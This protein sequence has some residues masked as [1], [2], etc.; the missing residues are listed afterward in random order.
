MTNAHKEKQSTDAVTGRLSGMPCQTQ[1][2]D[3]RSDGISPRT[4]AVRSIAAVG[5]QNCDFKF[6]GDALR[7]AMLGPTPV[8]NRSTRPTG[9]SILVKNG[10]PTVT[11]SCA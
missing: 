11:R 9:A 1:P 5:N 6:S 8:R 3:P 7:Q 2:D 4:I 10:G